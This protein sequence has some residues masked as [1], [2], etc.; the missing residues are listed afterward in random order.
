MNW[1][2]T[3]VD[4]ERLGLWDGRLCCESCHHSI[5]RGESGIEATAIAN[6]HGREPRV[7]VEVCCNFVLHPSDQTIE[8]SRDLFAAA[9]RAKRGAHREQLRAR[10]PEVCQSARPRSAARL[11]LT[12]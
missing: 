12:A 9:L 2:L 10:T 5:E 1:R 8:L 6:V 7:L 3:C 11:H 4:F